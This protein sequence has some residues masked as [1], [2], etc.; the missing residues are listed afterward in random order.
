MSSSLPFIIPDWPAPTKIHAVCTTRVGGI[1][2]SPYHSLNLG[3]HVG[4]DP[5]AV[6]QNRHT[7]SKALHLPSPPCW[8]TQVHGVRVINTQ[9]WQTGEEADGIY[10]T[11]PNAICAVM[12]AD[13]LPILLCDKKG[14][15]VAAIHAGWRGLADGIIES[16][17]AQAPCDPKE[18]MAWLG[19]AIG[20]KSFEAGDDVRNI[21]LS[22]NPADESGFSILGNSKWLVDMYHIARQRLNAVGVSNIYGEVE[23]TVLN[24]E[25]FFSFRREGITGRMASLIWI[26]SY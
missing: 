11:I 26:S 12:T 2:Q 1:S 25:R 9:N 24:P 4:D 13:C 6:T 17:I 16:T 23:C 22:Q 19:P 10:T 8:I 20:P 7:L 21:F 14:Q 3:D 15:Y 5:I 18:I